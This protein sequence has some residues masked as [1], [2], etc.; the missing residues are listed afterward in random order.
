[1]TS[2]LNMSETQHWEYIYKGSGLHVLIHPIPKQLG[3]L[4]NM[5]S[6]WGP[7]SVVCW[8]FFCVYRAHEHLSIIWDWH[9]ILSYFYSIKRTWKL[10]FRNLWHA[11]SFFYLCK[12]HFFFHKT[13]H[14]PTFS[15]PL[16]IRIWCLI[17]ISPVISCCWESVSCYW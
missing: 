14:L 9:V 1:M 8:I 6:F 11:E 13:D 4:R 7:A 2:E 12:L 5:F 3:L 17:N 15:T 16:N 10:C